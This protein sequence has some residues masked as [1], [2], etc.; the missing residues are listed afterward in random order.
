MGWRVW[1]E[2]G[3][4][5]WS[6][7]LALLP[8]VSPPLPTLASPATLLLAPSIVL[9]SLIRPQQY[10]FGVEQRRDNLGPPER[11]ARLALRETDADE[12]VGEEG[13]GRAGSEGGWGRTRRGMR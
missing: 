2:V 12:F 1:E 3:A 7:A 9:D 5:Y 11:L 8:L 6:A 4:G 13:E 10:S